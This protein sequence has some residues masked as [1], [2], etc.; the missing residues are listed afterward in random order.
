M[1]RSYVLA[2]R[3]VCSSAP[4]L[5]QALDLACHLFHKLFGHAY[6]HHHRVSAFAGGHLSHVTFIAALYED[7]R[8]GPPM[9]Q[10]PGRKGLLV[11]LRR[12]ASA[13]TGI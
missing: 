6:I 9:N 8:K 3:K 1:V 4:K 13:E 12:E 2:T 5:P 7:Q 11:I 10:P